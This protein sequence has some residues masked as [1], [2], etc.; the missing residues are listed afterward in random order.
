VLGTVVYLLLPLLFSHNSLARMEDPNESTQAEVVEPVSY[1]RELQAFRDAIAGVESDSGAYAGP[2]PEQLLS[3]GLALQNEGHHG[4]AVGIFRRGAHLARINNGLYSV[5]QIPHIR[6]KIISHLA[7]GELSEADESQARLF[8]IQKRNLATGGVQ[9]EA[10]LQQAR[11][12][13]QAYNLGLGGPEASFGRLLN[14]WDLNRLALTNTIKLKGDKSSNLL[15]PLNGMLQAQYLI[16][17]HRYRNK[18]TNSD[19]NTEMGSR[20]DQNR[21]TSYQNKSYEMGRSII[22]AIYDIQAYVHGEKSLQT[23][24]T[25]V[26]MG[27]WMWWHG[28]RDPA[29]EAY[30]H[31]IGELAELDDAQLQT[32]KLLGEPVALPDLDGVRPLPGEVSADEGNFL[33]EFGVTPGGRVVDLV[34]LSDTEDENHDIERSGWENRL[35][36]TLRKTKFRPRFVDG[37]AITT[38]KIVKAYAIA[39]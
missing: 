17:G 31:A 19:F 8:R 30:S 4:D 12:Q 34:R 27:D 2:L 3:L 1:S 5:A 16:S 25:R 13:Q 18:K 24:Q 33:V 29:M 26:M 10:L 20:Q 32:E 11:W 28:V 36:R 21:F 38:E 14:M 6:N 39:N 22:R 7:L 23:A 37:E 15:P 9:T 35:M